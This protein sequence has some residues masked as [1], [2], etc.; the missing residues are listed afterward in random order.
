VERHLEEHRAFLDRQYAAGHFLASG[1]QVPRIGGV[2]LA[3]GLSRRQLDEVLAQD[4]FCRER[5][6][7]YQVIE[8]TPVKAVA[9]LQVLLD[10]R[11]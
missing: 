10:A 9:G 8:F 2:I 11:S 4:P 5:I 1:P 6:A 7:Q 3:R